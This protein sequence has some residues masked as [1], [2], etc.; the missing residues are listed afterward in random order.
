MLQI[1]G[2][3]RDSAL[4]R[5]ARPLLPALQRQD[6]AFAQERPD[7][8][9]IAYSGRSRCRNHDHDPLLFEELAAANDDVALDVSKVTFIDS[10]GVGGLVF[11]Y[12]RL[13]AKGCKLELSGL[14]G[15]PR[16]CSTT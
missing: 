15:Q 13:N 11:L 8:Q 2:N 6:V 1:A 3:G 10:S 5:M 9:E 7:D 12:K 14:A 4:I 16:S